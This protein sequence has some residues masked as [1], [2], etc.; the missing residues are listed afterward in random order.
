MTGDWQ[1]ESP[2]SYAFKNVRLVITQT[3]DRIDLA[4]S[5]EFEGRLITN[6]TVLYPDGRG[7]SNL[8]R[9]PGDASQIE[10]RSKTAWKNGKLVRRS[11]FNT[12]FQI[13]SSQYL[14]RHT[15]TLTYTLSDD[16]KFLTVETRAT[17]EPLNGTFQPVNSYGK[18]TY[19]RKP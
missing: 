9:F 12:P 2:K 3:N 6:K 11:T 14:A 4:D 16:K 13:G 10:V 8:A 1:F 18:R 5:L 7:E 17:R 15:E 19:R